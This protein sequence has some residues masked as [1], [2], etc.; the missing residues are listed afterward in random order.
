MISK[1]RPE[2]ILFYNV[3]KGGVNTTDENLRGYSTEAAPPKW[4]LIVSFSL[5]D[6]ACLNAYIICKDAWI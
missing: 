3:T 6:I 4:P 1:R 5:L 2:A